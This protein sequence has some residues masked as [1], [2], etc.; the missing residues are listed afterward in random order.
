MGHIKWMFL[1][2]C[3][4][5]CLDHITDLRQINKVSNDIPMHQYLGEFGGDMIDYT[6]SFQKRKW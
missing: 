6:E 1:R 4:Y 5:G 3:Y 2:M